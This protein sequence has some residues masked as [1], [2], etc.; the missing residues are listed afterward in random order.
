MRE[1]ILDIEILEET[2]E[3]IDIKIDETENISE[4]EELNTKKEGIMIEL[5][6]RRIIENM[7][8]IDSEIALLYSKVQ[9]E[10]DLTINADEAGAYYSLR[11][12]S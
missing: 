7:E 11:Y 5:Y 3:D 2:K 1:N 6:K 12:P 8:K 10:T 4:K 9:I